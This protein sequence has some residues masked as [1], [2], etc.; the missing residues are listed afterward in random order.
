MMHPIRD[1]VALSNSFGVYPVV[2]RTTI[3]SG[4]FSFFI[5]IVFVFLVVGSWSRVR[6]RHTNPRGPSGSKVRFHGSGPI[7]SGARNHEVGFLRGLLIRVPINRGTSAR[8]RHIQIGRA[9]RVR[10]GVNGHLDYVLRRRHAREI[11]FLA[12]YGRLARGRPFPFFDQGVRTNLVLITRRANAVIG[13]CT[14]DGHLRAIRPS[15]ATFGTCIRACAR[16][17]RFTNV[18]VTTASLS[19]VCRH[20]RNGTY[21]C[22]CMCGIFKGL[23][24]SPSTLN[25][26][27]TLRVVICVTERTVCIQRFLYRL[28]PLYPTQIG[29]RPSAFIKVCAPCRTGARHCQFLIVPTRNASV[30]VRQQLSSFRHDLLVGM[31]KIVFLVPRGI[32]ATVRFTGRRLHTSWVGAWVHFRFLCTFFGVICYPRC[33]TLSK[34]RKFVL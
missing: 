9:C 31:A 30:V 4:S 14:N 13:A 8:R 26:Y 20:A 3:R 7:T 19:P 32:T 22:V 17:S 27:D 6:H 11:A 25:S 24:R 29:L 10:S 15:A 16:I 23:S 34:E 33:C 1:P 21:A 5:V 2:H 12:G 18:R 28:G